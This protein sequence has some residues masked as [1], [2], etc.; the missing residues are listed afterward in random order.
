M[1]VARARLV[2]AEVREELDLKEIKEMEPIEL[3]DGLEV[4]DKGVGSN[5]SSATR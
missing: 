2:A 3:E 5:P 4:E 1:M